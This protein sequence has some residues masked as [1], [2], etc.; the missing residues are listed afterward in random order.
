MQ[1]LLSLF[2]NKKDCMTTFWVL[3]LAVSHGIFDQVNQAIAVPKPQISNATEWLNIMKS[4]SCSRSYR[5]HTVIWWYGDTGPFEYLIDHSPKV[6]IPEFLSPHMSGEHWVCNWMMSPWCAPASGIRVAKVS[7]A[8]NCGPQDTILPIETSKEASVAPCSEY[9][10]NQRFSYFGTA[11]STTVHSFQ[12]W[13]RITQTAKLQP[14]ASKLS[15]NLIQCNSPKAQSASTMSNTVTFQNNY[16]AIS[17]NSGGY[18]RWRLVPLGAMIE[19]DFK[20]VIGAMTA[21]QFLKP[22]GHFDVYFYAG[23][24]YG[25]YRIILRDFYTFIILYY[26]K[27]F[28]YCY[29]KIQEF[30]NK[31]YNISPISPS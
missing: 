27:L 25:Q 19:K 1:S 20:N 9:L 21:L 12:S 13:A 8:L 15:L 22:T 11:Y 3:K 26:I 14:L 18:L 16:I 7:F 30:Y 31:F 28:L 6:W 5:S 10:F 4:I 23:P 2:P 29:R 17:I 24:Q